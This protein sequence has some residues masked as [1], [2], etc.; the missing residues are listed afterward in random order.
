MLSPKQISRLLT[1]AM[2]LVVIVSFV[3]CNKGVGCPNEF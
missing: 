2:V 3:A 1:I